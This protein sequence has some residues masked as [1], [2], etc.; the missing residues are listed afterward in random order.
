MSEERGHISLLQLKPTQGYETAIAEAARYILKP[1]IHQVSSRL[2]SDSV[3]QL[4]PS[5]RK[6][7][8]NKGTAQNH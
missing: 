3:T 1:E 4:L 8:L 6:V 7:P 5:A 2:C